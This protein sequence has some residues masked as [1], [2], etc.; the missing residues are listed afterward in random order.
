[1]D[2]PPYT[3]WEPLVPRDFETASIR[4]AAPSYLSE[5]PSYTSALP[6]TTSSRSSGLPSPY[7][8]STRHTR[9]GSIPSLDSFRVT[10]WSRTQPS[11]PA[12]R[13]YYSVARRRA[14]VLTAQ[15]Q[16][17]LL[18]ATLNG[19]DGIAQL[20]K[21][22]D[23]ES[24]ERDIRTL[25]D[26][27]L[28]GEEAA[29]KNRQERLKRENGYEVLEMENRRWD[30]LLAQMSDWEERDKSWRK[31]RQ[32]L[33]GGNRAKLARRLGMSRDGNRVL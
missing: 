19:D 2:P 20:K 5:A 24:R 3:P 17:S 28:V 31:F 25:E 1:M 11:N 29:E 16:A 32:E 13:H 9:A 15:E 22:M 23:E 7:L 14:S 26:P 4:S 27:R 18:T 12:A 21:K 33:Q 6:S 30:W 10:G 8:S